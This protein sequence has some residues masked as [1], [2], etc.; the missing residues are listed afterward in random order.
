MPCE[1]TLLT[2]DNSR[3]SGGAADVVEGMDDATAFSTH[4]SANH[5]SLTFSNGEAP[6]CPRFPASNC[7]DAVELSD[8]CNVDAAFLI[9][10]LR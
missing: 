7:R 4:A 10:N 6:L 8:F 5:E 2:A 3:R 1:L 9:L